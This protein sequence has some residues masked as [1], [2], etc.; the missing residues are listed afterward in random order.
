MTI[1]SRSAYLKI[2][3]EK[4][5]HSV[6]EFAPS[7]GEQT[8]AQ[9]LEAAIRSIASNGLDGTT[10][11]SVAKLA[12]LKRPH[13]VY[14]FANRNELIIGAMEAVTGTA[15]KI[16]VQHVANANEPKLILDAIIHG[17]YDWALRFP[18]QVP[19]LIAFQSIAQCNA[20]A[21]RLNDKI[22]NAGVRRLEAVLQALDATA[23]IPTEARFALAQDIQFLVLGSIMWFK[24]G[25]SKRAINEVETRIRELCWTM[26]RGVS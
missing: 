2:H 22:R 6:L 3:H 7:R 25:S 16:T 9:I 15:Q 8:R 23:N 5:L 18:D 24:P 20:E 19:V 12:G 14:Y 26:V 10:F 13:V 1:Y 17:A 4:A 21:R 11:E